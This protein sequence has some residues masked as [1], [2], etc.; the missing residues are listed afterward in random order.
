M[1]YDEPFGAAAAYSGES[2]FVTDTDTDALVSSLAGSQGINS[3][4]A[5][6]GTV[7]QLQGALSPGNPGNLTPQE[8]AQA[9]GQLIGLQGVQGVVDTAGQG[10]N[11]EVR[12]HNL[13]A[14]LGMK[15]GE[16][17]NFQIYGGPVAQRV[18]ADVKLRGTAYGPATGY[19]A[20]ISPDQDYGWLLVFHIVNLNLL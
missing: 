3:V 18:E 12:S 7:A 6:E 4:A 15:L 10:T 11:V 5:L 20:N 17:K 13:T 2:N 9:Q 1:L 19:T 16:N 14:I 8:L